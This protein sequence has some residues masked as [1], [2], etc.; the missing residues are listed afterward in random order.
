MLTLVGEIWWVQLD[1]I[2][3]PHELLITKG[4]SGTLQLENLSDHPNKEIKVISPIM[5]ILM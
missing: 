4:K 5:Y 2:K 1:Y 3:H